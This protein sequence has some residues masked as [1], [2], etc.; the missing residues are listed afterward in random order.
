MSPWKQ[1]TLRS[2]VGSSIFHTTSFSLI[3]DSF[4][5]S[6]VVVLSASPVSTAVTDSDSVMCNVIVQ[7]KVRSGEVMGRADR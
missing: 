5:S 2:L 3:F 7:G 1:Q 4:S 6:V